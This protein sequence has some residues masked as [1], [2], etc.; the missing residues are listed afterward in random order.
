MR[1]LI[2]IVAATLAVTLALALSG[3]GEEKDQPLRR[4]GVDEKL[5]E[6]VEANN[7]AGVREAID[8]WAN[9]NARDDNGQ[10][11][12]HLAAHGGFSGAVSL[13]LAKGADPNARNSEGKTPLHMAAEAGQ[14]DVVKLLLEKWSDVNSRDN[15]GETPLRMAAAN[16]HT[17]AAEAL[18]KKWADVNAM[19]NSGVTPL[20]A[21]VTNNQYETAELLRQHGGVE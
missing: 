1:K 10:T 17:K 21:A 19:D 16:G 2:V 20:K 8:G 12:L 7:P 18:L 6:A 15:A 14:T 11:P 4:P 3:C 5:F 9:V 13:L